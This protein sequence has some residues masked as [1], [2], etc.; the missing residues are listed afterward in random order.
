MLDTFVLFKHSGKRLPA[1]KLYLSYVKGKRGIEIGGPSSQFRTT[2]PLYPYVS[3]L[4]GVNVFQHTLWEGRILA[5]RTYNYFCNRKG[6]QYI[7]DTTDLS[8]LPPASYDFLLS[9]NCLEHIANP[10]KALLEWKRVVRIGGAIVL[11]LPNPKS[12]FD[13]RRPV[14]A[15]EHLLQDLQNSTAEDDLT[16]LDEIFALHDLSRDPQA[17]TLDDFRARSIDNYQNR[18]LH[19]HIFSLEL[20]VRMLT[21]VGLGVKEAVESPRDLYALAVRDN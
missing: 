15:F 18:A 7:S 8:A 10:L 4:D 3:D 5:G 2:L 17:G 11:I 16:H 1:H 9:S 12:N 19:H 14:T 6:I 20:M 21:H 13:H